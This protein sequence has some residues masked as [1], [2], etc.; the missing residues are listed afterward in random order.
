MSKNF[1]LP[2]SILVLLMGGTLS[3]AQVY[4]AQDGNATF[5][6][7]M[8]LNSYIGQTDQLKGT[9]DFKTGKVNF[10]L[11]VK[12]IKTGNE[13]RDGH[14]YEMLETKKNPDVVFEGKLID[15]FDREEKSKR[16]VRAKGDFTLA[17]SIRKITIPLDLEPVSKAI[18]LNA[19]WSLLITDYGLE[20]PSL[21]FI[22]VDDKH[23]LSVDALLS[24][25]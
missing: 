4:T 8:P 5:E 25:Q 22:K 11:P 20:R 16:T 13:K 9:I 23:D 2:L 10:S 17:G 3:F 1:I 15:D 21:M 6:A 19:S 18:Q 24:A 12:S 14:M 7:K